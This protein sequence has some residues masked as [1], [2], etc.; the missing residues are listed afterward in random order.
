MNKCFWLTILFPTILFASDFTKLFV[1]LG[2]LF[3]SFINL[4]LGII[5]F[6]KSGKHKREKVLPYQIVILTFII[7]AVYMLIDEANHMADSDFFGLL[8]TILIPSL[9]G[10]ITPF[11]RKA[12]NE[13]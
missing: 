8:I 4:I 9:F 5:T 1:A 2:C 3:I 13:N 10:L 12:K 6:V 7:I 11:F